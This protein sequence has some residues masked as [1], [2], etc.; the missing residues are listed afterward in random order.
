MAEAMKIQLFGKEFRVIQDV[1]PILRSACTTGGPALVIL[2]VIGCAAAWFLS[3]NRPMASDLYTCHYSNEVYDSDALLMQQKPTRFRLMA[4]RYVEIV[5]A[6]RGYNCTGTVSV[7]FNGR[8]YTQAGMFDDPGIAEL[9]P[10]ISSLIGISLADT[11]DLT[12]FSVISV[13][14]M[15]GYAGFWR[16]HPNQRLRWVGGAVFLCLGLA[17][18]AVADV[19]IF[20]ISPLIAGIPWILYFGLS[21]K[22]FAL[23]A[24][25]I[26]LAF[27]CS[28]CS[29]VRSGTTLICVGFLIALFIGRCRVQ[30]IVLPSLLIILAC[31]PSMIFEQHLIA[32]RD[33]ALARIGEIPT[34]LNS[35]PLWHSIYIGLGFIHNSEVPEYNDAVALNKVRSIDPTVPYGSKKY[36]GILKREVFKLAKHRPMLLIETLAAKAGIVIL[37]A[38]IVLAPARRFL[39]SERK[40]LWLDAAFVVSIGMSAMGPILVVPRLPYLLTF[41]CL[42]LLYSSVKLCRGLLFAMKQSTRSPGV[43]CL[44]GWRF[45]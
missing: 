42:T 10:T 36:D 11:Y 27:S 29:L 5:R 6:A 2:I 43:S 31:V 45:F 15:I 44:I 7:A 8:N 40:V 38:A 9:I 30:K 3:G 28:W 32:R 35:H 25:A 13:G 12:V 20:Q 18:A 21:G 34:A 19:Y 26:L 39:L 23:D 16:L 41:L 24:S 4:T 37:L 14:I 22:A 1:G 33:A 17:E